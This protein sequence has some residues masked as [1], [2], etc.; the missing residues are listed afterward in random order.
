MAES[1]LEV[2][3]ATQIGT[4]ARH[5]IYSTQLIDCNTD[6]LTVVKMIWNDVTRAGRH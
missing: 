5:R 4:H 2:D 6:V 3:V 1:G